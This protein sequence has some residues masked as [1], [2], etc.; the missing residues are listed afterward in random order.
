MASGLKLGL[1][2]QTLYCRAG[3]SK[4]KTFFF[5][6]VTNASLCYILRRPCE[7]HALCVICEPH[8][9][10]EASAL[11]TIAPGQPA[12]TSHTPD[13]RDIGA[14]SRGHRRRFRSTEPPAEDNAPRRRIQTEMDG[15][16]NTAS[17]W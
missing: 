10:Q 15:V 5:T 9:T 7:Y 14:Q 4:C 16:E 3:L 2:S 8:E 12:T 6:R 1:G 11:S 13:V 17:L